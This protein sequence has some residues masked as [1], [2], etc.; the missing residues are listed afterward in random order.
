MQA[1]Y[2]R[3]GDADTYVASPLTRG[4]WH[5]DHQHGGPPAA[6]LARAFEALAPTEQWHPARFSIEFLRPVAVARPLRAVAEVTRSGSSVLGLA[7][8]LLD[9]DRPVARGQLLCVRRQPLTLPEGAAPA[10]W[11]VDLER[12]PSFVFP[13]FRWD[14][15]YHTAIEGRLESGT[16]G[17]GPAVAWLRP[18]HPLIAGEPT[19]PL[20]NTLIVADAINGVGFVLDLARYSFINA[21]LTLYLHRL[22]Q[23]PWIRL[24]AT[25]NPQPTGVGMVEAEVGDVHGPIG[26][27]LEAQVIVARA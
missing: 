6:L 12:L 22:P 16:L 19:S 11:N 8:A 9:G 17:A 4:P 5:I 7:G 3:D 26:R 24:A 14:V 13:F 1:F 2:S 15:G 20:Q 21:E 18:R 25:P 23:G 10:G 27:A